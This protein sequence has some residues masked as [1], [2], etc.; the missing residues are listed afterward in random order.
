MNLDNFQLSETITSEKR[1]WNAWCI[2]PFNS[3]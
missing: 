2:K 1:D 3:I